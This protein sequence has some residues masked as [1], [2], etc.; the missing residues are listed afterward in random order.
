MPV[1]KQPVCLKPSQLTIRKLHFCTPAY[2]SQNRKGFPV[3]DNL[4]K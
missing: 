3:T 1:K 4:E 2:L